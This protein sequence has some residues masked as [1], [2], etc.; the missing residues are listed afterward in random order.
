MALAFALFGVA[1]SLALV[2]SSS[3]AER[4]APG[5]SCGVASDTLLLQRGARVHTEVRPGGREELTEAPSGEESVDI[6]WDPSEGRRLPLCHRRIVEQTCRKFHGVPMDAPVDA[7]LARVSASTL[8]DQLSASEEVMASLWS[9]LSLPDDADDVECK[10]LCHSVVQYIT[11]NGGHLPPSTDVACYSVDGVTACDADADPFTLTRALAAVADEPLPDAGARVPEYDSVSVGTDGSKGG[12]QLVQMATSVS[13]EKSREG[14]GG[15][16]RQVVRRFSASD[17]DAGEATRRP[18]AAAS[19]SDSTC[20]YT[21][22]ELVERVASLFRMHPSD[23]RD[24]KISLPGASLLQNSWENRAPA[25]VKRRIAMTNALARAWV[26]TV[27]GEMQGQRAGEFRSK[28]FGGNGTPS[29][30]RTRTRVL[31]TMNFIDQVLLDRVRYVYPADEAQRTSCQGSV[32]AYVWRFQTRETG[33]VETRGPVCRESQD[34]FNE[35]CAMDPEGK[36]FVY[37]CKRWYELGGENSQ[38]STLV[39]EAAHHSGPDDVTYDR[40]EMR[41]NERAQQLDNA[42]NYQYF[43]QDVAQSAWG[44][45]DTLPFD[46]H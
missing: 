25:E 3:M 22:W 43:A 26:S 34:P 2:V 19:S 42:A 9:A 24:L 13:S 29:E 21:L 12:A 45:D 37:L 39:H 35:I 10:Q 32:V 5:G 31:R 44:C 6:Q 40:G 8:R 4:S 20:P 17:A 23:G 1:V 18:A 11:E 36:Y 16:R 27:V 7:S 33:Y 41:R 46:R 14:I 15:L 28:W 38:I 30:N